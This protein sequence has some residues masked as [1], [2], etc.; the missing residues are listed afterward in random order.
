MSRKHENGKIH[1]CANKDITRKG[2]ID[3]IS[4]KLIGWKLLH[5]R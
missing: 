4:R 1:A 5:F 2:D 3:E